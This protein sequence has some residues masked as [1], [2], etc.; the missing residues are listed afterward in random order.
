MFSSML[1]RMRKYLISFRKSLLVRR[2][3]FGSLDKSCFRYFVLSSPLSCSLRES[4][5]CASR[6]NDALTTADNQEEIEPT[7]VKI[8]AGTASA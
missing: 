8:I 2:S 5:S 6:R 1:N 3:F 7:E 4:L